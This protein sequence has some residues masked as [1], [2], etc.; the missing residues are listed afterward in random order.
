M[1]RCVDDDQLLD[2]AV[3]MAGRAADAPPELVQRIKATL[4]GVAQVADHGTAVERELVD[5]VWSIGQPAFAERLAAMQQKISSPEAD[6]IRRS[7]HHGRS[8]SATGGHWR[9][10]SRPG[11]RAVGFRH[12]LTGR[13]A[14]G[15]R[16]MP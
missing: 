5:Q 11:P 3:E 15:P 8:G 10:A 14:H 16:G 4:A 13:Q 6:L 12:H 9:S 2:V 7:R 1:W